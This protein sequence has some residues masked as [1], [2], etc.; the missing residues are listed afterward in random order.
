MEKYPTPEGATAFFPE[1][2]LRDDEFL[3]DSPR[4]RQIVHLPSLREIRSKKGRFPARA[5][6]YLRVA[7]IVPL[8]FPRTRMTAGPPGG[9]KP[10]GEGRTEPSSVPG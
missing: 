4:L 5:L 1:S 3:A 8:G 7:D 10:P 2:I 6:H 9:G